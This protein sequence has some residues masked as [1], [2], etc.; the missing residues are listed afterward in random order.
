MNPD[1]LDELFTFPVLYS[2]LW[3]EEHPH[4]YAVIEHLRKID[5]QYTAIE[6]AATE[7]IMHPYELIEP[8]LPEY[9]YYLEKLQLAYVNIGREFAMRY[10]LGN[11]NTCLAMSAEEL[12]TEADKKFEQFLSQSPY[13]AFPTIR[14]T[15]SSI[16]DLPAVYYDAG[17]LSNFLQK[18]AYLF[19][20]NRFIF[21]LAGV[22]QALAEYLLWDEHFRLYRPLLEL[23]SAAYIRTP[24]IP[25][26]LLNDPRITQIDA[27]HYKLPGRNTNTP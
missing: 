26:H 2:T 1:D 9:S 19:L 18:K 4:I 17:A 7:N 25:E 15:I 21:S 24:D 14:D 20:S 27:V 12:R 16:A 3:D 13:L 8:Y 22:E 10:F 23:A 6:L 11:I 5:P